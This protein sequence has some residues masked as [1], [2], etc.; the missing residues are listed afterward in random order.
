MEVGRLYVSLDGWTFGTFHDQWG[1]RMAGLEAS[2]QLLMEAG[3]L[4]CRIM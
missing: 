2:G 4:R 3:G 1:G